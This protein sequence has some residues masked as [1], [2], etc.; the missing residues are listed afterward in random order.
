MI[1]IWY[2]DNRCDNMAHTEVNFYYKSFRSLLS[3]TLLITVGIRQV[4]NPAQNV[5]P[6]QIQE[7]NN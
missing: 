1:F 7:L 3:P 5:P 2:A 4:F 6:K